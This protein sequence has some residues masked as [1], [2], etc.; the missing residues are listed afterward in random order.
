[1]RKTKEKR[2][3]ICYDQLSDEIKALNRKNEA[4]FIPAHGIKTSYPNLTPHLV[5]VRQ[6]LVEQ[7]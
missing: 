6:T 2:R 5:G 4:G 1:M 7:H 3:A